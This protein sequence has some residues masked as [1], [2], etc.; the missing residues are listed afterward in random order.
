MRITDATRNDIAQIALNMRESDFVEFRALLPPDSRGDMADYLAS[1]YGSLSDVHVAEDYD[2]KIAVFS[3]IQLRPNVLSLMFFA[4]DKFQS[5]YFPLTRFLIRKYLTQ[6]INA[7]A[8][9]MECA[10]IF[11]HH[12]AHRWISVLGLKK[13]AFL[14]KYG[15]NQE[16]F[17]QFS[18]VGGGLYAG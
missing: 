1:W 7:G 9:R 4:T 11:G 3:A 2:D 18:W 15:K 5:I 6:K 13:E 16:N 17:V 10:S 12:E 8:H 14:P